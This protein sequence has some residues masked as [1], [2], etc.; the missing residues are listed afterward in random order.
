MSA[1]WITGNRPPL[2]PWRYAE[3]LAYYLDKISAMSDAV[4]RTVLPLPGTS[5]FLMNGHRQPP[6]RSGAREFCSTPGCGPRRRAIELTARRPLDILPGD[7]PRDFA[8]WE[9]DEQHTP[10]SR[11]R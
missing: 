9:E 1:D 11:G 7:S 4:N 2:W 5:V 6:R 10:S 8:D 3:L